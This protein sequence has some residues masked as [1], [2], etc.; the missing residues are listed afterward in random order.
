M[1]D[2]SGNELV[3]TEVPLRHLEVSLSGEKMITE[4]ARRGTHI[5]HF[6][7]E[8][9]SDPQE[10]PEPVWNLAISPDG[11]FSVATWQTGVRFFVNG[12]L[13]GTY[14]LPLKLAASVAVSDRGEILV[15]G[16]TDTGTTRTVLLSRDGTE[17]WRH[18]GE[19]ELNA[20]RP[21]VSFFPGGDAFV[22]RSTAGLQAYTIDRS[23]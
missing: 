3:R 6:D 22:V 1:L 12:E 9:M 13:H 21:D 10:F 7:H 8:A 15:G 19:A 4:L 18:D 23:N 16:K 20:Y 17:R 14:S 2:Q 5:V 11:V